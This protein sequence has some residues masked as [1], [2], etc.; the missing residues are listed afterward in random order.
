MAHEIKP[1]VGAWY[2]DLEGK[3][4]EVVA[5]D[6]TSV[7]LQYFDGATAEADL[8]VWYDMELE[9]IPEP[10]DWSGPYDNVMKDDFGDTD[11][12]MHPEEWNGPLDELDRENY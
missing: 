12:A 4:F 2:K 6:E 11:R 10:E 3:S 7:E 8:D 1:V 9:S 5:T